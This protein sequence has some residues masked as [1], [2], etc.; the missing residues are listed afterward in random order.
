[1]QE[2]ARRWG[3]VG[4]RAP[5]LHRHHDWMPLLGFDYDSSSPDTDPYEPKAG[6]CLTWLP[7]FNRELVELPVTIPQDHTVFVILRRS[8]EALWSEKARYLRR[9]G[10]MAVM[11]THP[12]YMLEE[13]RL[14]AYRR[15]LGEFAADESAWKALPREVSAWWRRRAASSLEL[16][17]GEWHVVGPAA[18]EARIE[19]AGEPA[20]VP[21][22]A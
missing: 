16:R 15:F 1:M 22:A 3:A 17:D 20:S 13:S 21:V 7:Y 11:L 5:A 8:D 6:G 19:L 18:G 9:R 2:W 10:G 14:A 12:D 4:F